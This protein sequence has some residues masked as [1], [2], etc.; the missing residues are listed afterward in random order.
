M[1]FQSTRPRGARQPGGIAVVG[2]QVFQ[3]TRPRGARPSAS[4]LW[5]ISCVFQSTRP[6]G[7]RLLSQQTSQRRK[8]V[9]IHAPTWGATLRM[10]CWGVER[11]TFQSTRPRGA[12]PPL[13]CQA[14]LYGFCFNPR[15]HVGRDKSAARRH[16]RSSSFNPRAHVG[17][18]N[19]LASGLGV[20]VLFQS[21]RPRGARP[22]HFMVMPRSGSTFQ[23]TRPRGARP[24]LCDAEFNDLY[25]F[26]PRAHVGRDSVMFCFKR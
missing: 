3:S 14:H 16:L 1:Q 17:R 15:A 26:N 19:L 18:D 10:L 12:R 21:T 9:S 22:L 5:S 24:I 13:S 2:R 4:Q 7:A 11:I 6:R 23:S 20:N 8:P 25:S